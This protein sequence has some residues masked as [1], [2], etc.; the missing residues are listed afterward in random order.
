M[1]GS[2]P[3]YAGLGCLSPPDFFDE[4]LSALRLLKKLSAHPLR[5]RLEALPVSLVDFKIDWP[6]E[7]HSKNLD[8]RFDSIQFALKNG[9]L[10]VIGYYAF[11]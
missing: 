6:T 5:G 3:R 2:G 11:A 7:R 10:H 8:F 1:H 9:V 4:I